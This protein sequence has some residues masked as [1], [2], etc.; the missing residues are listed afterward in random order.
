MMAGDVRKFVQAE[1]QRKAN[2][3]IHVLEDAYLQI[4]V[5]DRIIERTEGM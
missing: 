1:I 3:G 2:S 4:E 5:A